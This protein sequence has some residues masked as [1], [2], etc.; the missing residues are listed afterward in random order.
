MLNVRMI[1]IEEEGRICE[2]AV[3]IFFNVRT[4]ILPEFD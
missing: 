4:R 3:F 1:V 2:E